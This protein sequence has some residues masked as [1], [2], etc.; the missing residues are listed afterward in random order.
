MVVGFNREGAKRIVDAVKRVEQMPQDR[1]GGLRPVLEPGEESFWAMLTDQLDSN[2]QLIKGR[3]GWMR[4]QPVQQ[5][6]GTVAFRPFEPRVFGTYAFEVNQHG[7]VPPGS[8]VKLTLTA[9]TP[10]DEPVY[11]FNYETPDRASSP[12]PIHDHRDNY[13]G[14]FAFAVFHPGTALPQQPWGI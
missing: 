8:I 7:P 14:G 10:E 2:D 11:S 3:Y 5:P 9:Y 6:D 4:V 12:M 13:N 1:T